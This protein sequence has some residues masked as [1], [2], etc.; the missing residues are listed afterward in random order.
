[1]TGLVE[2]VAWR[3]SAV[4]RPDQYFD[5]DGEADQWANSP[6]VLDS[7]V[8]PLVLL[9]QLQAAEAAQLRYVAV[10]H[11]GCVY[12]AESQ[13]LAIEIAKR[14]QRT[15]VETAEAERGCDPDGCKDHI[16]AFSARA[17]AAEAEVSKLKAQVETARVALEP[18]AAAIAGY[19]AYWAEQTGGQG[20][21][22]GEDEDKATYLGG[23]G[24]YYDLVP[25]GAFRT[26]TQALRALDEVND[27]Q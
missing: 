24:D 11:T 23:V 27:G 26:A 25:L 3:V 15:A 8:T 4:D 1:M 2:P 12:T 5:T 18:F 10:D 7:V 13:E 22:D 20:H 16:E 6:G 14:I 19:D 9:S 21:P 17:E